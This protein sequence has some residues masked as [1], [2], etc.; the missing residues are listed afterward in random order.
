MILGVDAGFP[1]RGVATITNSMT[2]L[3]MDTRGSYPFSLGEAIRFLHAGIF[4][5]SGTSMQS[6]V[7]L[8]TIF[9]HLAARQCPGAAWRQQQWP[10]CSSYGDW[11]PHSL[12]DQK[13]LIEHVF[14][15]KAWRLHLVR[16]II[17]ARKEAQSRVFPVAPLRHWH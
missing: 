13:E 17:K 12:L 6:T 8:Y 16:I 4:S 2:V 7:R 9:H 11:Y 14:P 10:V 15:W 5:F 1:K 3:R